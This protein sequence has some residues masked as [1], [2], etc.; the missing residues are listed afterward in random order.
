ML[1][2]VFEFVHQTKADPPWIP[3]S[4]PYQITSPGYD[5]IQGNYTGNGNIINGVRCALYIYNCS[6]VVVDGQNNFV[7]LASGASYGVCIGTSDFR[8]ENLDLENLVMSGGSY[9]VF[10]ANSTDLTLQND[11]FVGSIFVGDTAS[12][13]TA[14]TTITNC[15]ISKSASF[16]SG[17]I[18]ASGNLNMVDSIVNSASPVAFSL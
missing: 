1:S 18:S 7:N 6:D 17:S 3:I 12:D 8:V 10:S 9:C 14:T 5:Q 13:S 16:G 4:L 15:T 11:I 2:S